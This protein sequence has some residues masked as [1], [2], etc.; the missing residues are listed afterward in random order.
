MTKQDEI[1]AL[2]AQ[3]ADFSAKLDALQAQ[4][5]KAE[6]WEPKGG[7]WYVHL[8]GTVTK[9]ESFPDARAFGVEHPTEEAAKSALPYMRFH[10]RLLCLAAELNPSGK[11]GGKWFVGPS[12]SDGGFTW[13]ESGAAGFNC[14]AVFETQAVAKRA[15][16]IL[17]RDGWKIET[18]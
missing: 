7:E 18:T 15:A 4:S 2:R 3:L 10:N 13:N 8:E 6:K 11:V 5:D 9:C 14:L 17:N 1:A 12:L 16:D